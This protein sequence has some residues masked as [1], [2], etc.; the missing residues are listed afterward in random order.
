MAAPV[1][2]KRSLGQNFLRDENTARKIMR[3]FQPGMSDDVL[4]IGPG[5]GA[6]TKYLAG[7]CRRLI[8]IEK[9][10]RSTE[11]LRK[12]FGIIPGTEI[13]EGDFLRTDIRSFIAGDTVRVIGS[14]PYNITSPLLMRLIGQREW[15]S[16]ALLLVQLE[17]ARRLVAS[18]G[19]PDY[20]TLT[21]LLQT[22]SDV[23]ILFRVPPSVFYPVPS[24]ESAI[25]RIAFKRNKHYIAD[26]TFYRN[27]V[28]GTFGK[29]RKMLRASLRAMFP[30]VVLSS[31]LIDVDLKRR[32]ESLTV[33]EFTKLS[34]QLYEVVHRC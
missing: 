16:D 3:A 2:P 26:E 7:K 25:V 9:D 32:P 8:L 14:I 18:P 30:D 28:E 27:I 6:L 12:T 15:L 22:W 1:K 33:A 13:I 19:T 5:M 29:R 4:E 23:A 31:G 20:G 21:V 34:N 11:L 24:V 10:T 17:V